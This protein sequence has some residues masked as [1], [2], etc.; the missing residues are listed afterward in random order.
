MN[1]KELHA[2]KNEYRAS[3]I[4]LL[5]MFNSATERAEKQIAA[6]DFEKLDGAIIGIAHY[7][8]IMLDAMLQE[9]K[10]N[11]SVG[12]HVLNA[13]LIATEN[14]KLRLVEPAEEDA[15]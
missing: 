6:M 12:V 7:H 15:A 1:S 8:A 10:P 3:I 11:F 14:V 5:A 9:I 13:A 4:G 2:M